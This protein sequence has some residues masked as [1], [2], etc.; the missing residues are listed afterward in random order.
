MRFPIWKLMALVVT[1]AILCAAW[2]LMPPARTILIGSVA[3][4]LA[5]EGIA[6]LG[7]RNRNPYLGVAMVLLLVFSLW[8]LAAVGLNLA[9]TRRLGAWLN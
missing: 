9:L 6:W 3:A 2:K 1:A 4:L 8:F 7:R 5:L